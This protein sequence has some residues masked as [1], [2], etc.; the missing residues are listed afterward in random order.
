M[1]AEDKSSH[2]EGISYETGGRTDV[3][4]SR[5]G[6]ESLQVGQKAQPD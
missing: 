3:I 5:S 4:S 1:D 6:G 2:C